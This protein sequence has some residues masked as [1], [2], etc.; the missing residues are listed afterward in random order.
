[1]IIMIPPF[2][3]QDLNRVWCIEAV[4]AEEISTISLE[5]PATEHVL[6]LG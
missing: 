2:V 4:D 5:Y 1:M 6:G 3:R